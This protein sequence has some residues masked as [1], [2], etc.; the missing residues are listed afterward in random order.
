MRLEPD[1]IMIDEADDGDRHREQIGGD[2][3]YVV[4]R[5][6][7]R[8][9]ENIVAAQGGEPAAF[10]GHAGADRFGL[11]RRRFQFPRLE[12]SGGE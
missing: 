8:R 7:R 2:G 12:P 6:V 11:V 3:G 9:I 4:E 1:P 10:L 5:A